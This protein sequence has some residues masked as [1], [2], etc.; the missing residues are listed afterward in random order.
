VCHCFAEAVPSSVLQHCLPCGK[1]WHTE[2][3]NAGYGRRAVAIA[4][5]RYPNRV[6]S[7]RRM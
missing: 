6:W 7:P 3:R 4:A 1:Q 2:V 5:G